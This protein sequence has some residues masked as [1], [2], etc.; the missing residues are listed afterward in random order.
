MKRFL[1]AIALVVGLAGLVAAGLASFHRGNKSPASDYQ[2]STVRRGDLTVSINATGT[3]EPEEVIDVGAQ[4][5]GRISSFGKDKNGKPVDYGS[6]VEAGIVLARI[7]ESLY[8]SDVDQAKAALTQS[9]ANQDRAE[10]QLHVATAQIGVA[11]ANLFPK[12]SLPGSAGY[13]SLSSGALG[14]LAGQFWSFGPGMTLPIFNAGRIRANVR[15]QTAAQQEA[16]FGYQQTVLTAL[17]DVETSL[18]SYAKDQQHQAAL[19]EAVKF[20]QRAVDL[21]TQAYTAGQVDFLNVLTAERNLYAS[22]DALVQS[23][24]TVITDLIALFKALGGGWQ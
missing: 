17:G 5:A 9:K 23:N 15:L 19:A 14:T 11:K 16:F 7:D 22:E 1:R 13:Q 3:L 6:I 4:V 12:F 21:A 2:F 24:R 8:Q 20:N 10:A 18:I